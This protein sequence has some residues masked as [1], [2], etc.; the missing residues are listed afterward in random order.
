[1]PTQRRIR[2]LNGE[3]L[4]EAEADDADARAIAY[5]D[6]QP[7]VEGVVLL[8][9]FFS[10][11]H[12][13]GPDE[14]GSDGDHEGPEPGG[15]AQ[16][17]AAEERAANGNTPVETRDVVEIAVVETEPVEMDQFRIPG[18]VIGQGDDDEEDEGDAEGDLFRAGPRSLVGEIRSLA[19]VAGGGPGAVGGSF[20]IMCGG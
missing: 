11:F 5:D 8:S 17:R 2:H 4:G 3:E 15:V 20:R 10:P 9:F 19:R 7:V 14:T 12:D 18:Q 6:T 1:M 16:E 13:H